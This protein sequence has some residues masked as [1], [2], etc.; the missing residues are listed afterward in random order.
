M[1]DVARSI[2]IDPRDYAFRAARRSRD[3]PNPFQASL[4]NL[5]F[6]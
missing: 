3:P 1:T 4:T 5:I 6:V 2:D